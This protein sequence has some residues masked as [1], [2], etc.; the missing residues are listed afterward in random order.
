MGQ[1]R[2]AWCGLVVALLA[3]FPAHCASYEPGAARGSGEAPATGRQ[4]LVTGNNTIT[5]AADEFRTGWYPDQPGLDPGIVA[6]GGFGRAFQTTL[7][8]TPKEQVYAQPLVS[9]DGSHVFIATQAN[10]LYVLDAKTGA[11][12]ASRALGKPWNQSDV[13]CGDVMPTI[14]V[15]STP[16]IDVT[17]NTAYLLSKSYDA[18]GAAIWYF[19][20]VD[21]TAL[22]ERPG[23][24]VTIAGAADN[25]P[26][27]V[28]TPKYQ[29][30]RT[31]LLLLNGVVY[32]G[33]SAHCDVGT[34]H[35]WIVGVSTAG[36]IV[37]RFA[38]E[39]GPMSNGGAG[40]WHS[41]GGLISDGPGRILFVTGNGRSPVPSGPV[42]ENMPTVGLGESVVRVDVQP[43]GGVKPG[44]WFSPYNAGMLGDEDMSSGGPVALPAPLFGTPATPNLLVIGGKHGVVYT[45]D[46][47]HLG[48]FL[49]GPGATDNAIGTIKVG[50]GMWSKPAVWP[51][52]GGWIYVDSSGGVGIQALKYSLNGQGVPTFAI[53]GK[54]TDT[55]G[56]FAGS[57][58]VTSNGTNAG[59]ALVWV[60]HD[61]GQLR[62]Y[63]AVPDATGVL[64]MVF[65]D[66]FG[67]HVKMQSPGVGAGTIFVGTNDGHVTGYAARAAVISGPP[68]DFGTVIVGN[69]KTATVTL[70][71][72]QATTVTALTSSDPT[73]FAVGAATPAL[74]AKLA[75]NQSMTVQVTFSPPQPSGYAAA[76]NVTSS[77]GA[78]G[79]PLK[80][81]G[82]ANGPYL[83][84]SPTSIAFGT[85]ATGTSNPA[86][87]VLANQG[88]KALTFAS[89][90]PP[91]APY[92]AMGLP[93][94]GQTLAPGATVTT[95]LVFA[96][97]ADGVYTSNLGVQSDGG[98]LTIAVT[99]SAAPMPNMVISPL[100]LDFG[101]VP[102][103]TTKTM[104]FTIANTGGSN[105]TIVKSKPP[106]QGIFTATTS[107]PE[108]TVV[109][110]GASLTETVAAS[111]MGSGDFTDA[112]I[113]T[114]N[115][116]SAL[117]TVTFAIQ[118]GSDAGA[119]GG[120]PPGTWQ[121]LPRTD[122]STAAPGRSPPAR[123]LAMGLA[124]AALSWARRWRRRAR[125]EVAGTR[126]TRTKCVLTPD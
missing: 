6:S 92:S 65:S 75:A 15:I 3:A 98:N 46:R 111:V 88:S 49:Q 20:A 103:G 27:I 102:P 114:G 72:M 115:D 14:G 76:L 67:P 104:S 68:V 94:A 57:P 45:L 23:F 16:V 123:S 126:C 83:A 50:G 26:S 89:F 28:F 34:Y 21:A 33:F 124:V 64:T 122:C 87:I 60:T 106:S 13:A 42:P 66:N 85:V 41:G 32:A 47:D 90:A 118:D 63:N 100:N 107:L 31:G 96:P 79:A 108:G 70:T 119:A 4:S 73:A 77:A 2:C 37:A 93:A 8:L 99:G 58:I 95:T 40:I 105:L 18:T 110:P 48:G 113:I 5:Q 7:T 82:Q 1:R 120:T 84:A 44:Q 91:M 19:H 81:T 43:G 117:H 97:T 12:T 10:N 54:T 56:S 11:I 55:F 125:D 53:V 61:S 69:M 36:Q 22:D 25:N 116:R 35:G 62:A 109:A 78:G 24:P 52:D 17:S 80:G 29:N 38:T 86:S 74:P 39:A 51:G 101:N 59:S 71:A 112:W 30:Q 121:N 9:S